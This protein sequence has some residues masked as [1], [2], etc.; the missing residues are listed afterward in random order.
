MIDLSSMR[1]IRVD[2]NHRVARVEPGCLLADLDRETQ[3]FGLATP[4]GTVSSTGV[5]GLTLG[6]GLGW[7]SRKYGLTL[8]NLLSV[9]VV[10]ADGQLVTASETENRELFWGIRAVAATSGL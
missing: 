5:A 10:T 8:D 9:D 7:L 6:G 1:A 2:P 4:A 3:A